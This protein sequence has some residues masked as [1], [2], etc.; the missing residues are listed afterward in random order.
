MFMKLLLTEQILHRHRYAGALFSA[1]V[2]L[3]L[4]GADARAQSLQRV[5]QSG[6]YEIHD[7]WRY[8]V[9]VPTCIRCR[10][11]KLRRS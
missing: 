7:S 11:I 9:S 1:A 6:D 8:T 10:F 5:R 3:V 4:T 2:M